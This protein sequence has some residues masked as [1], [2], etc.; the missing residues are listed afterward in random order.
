MASICGASL[1]LMAAGVPIKAPVAG[2]AMGLIQDEKRT[3]ILSD[4]LGDEDHLGD[5]DFKVAGTSKGITAMQMDI[6]ITGLTKE[7]LGKALEQAR[8]GRLHILEKMENTIAQ[9]RP[10]LSPL[11]PKLTVLKVPVDRI[12]DLIGPGGKNIRKII[13]ETGAT[14]DI[15]DDG[16][17]IIGA[18]DQASGDL[19]IKRVKD[20]TAEVEVGKYYRGKVVRIVDFGAFVEVYPKV[21]G[22]VHIS[23][24]EKRRVEKVSE[25]LKVGDMITVKCIEIDKES[26]KIRLSRKEALDYKGPLENE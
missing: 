18:T 22:L 19:A 4:I 20:Y 13:E 16:T 9:P 10:A 23:H 17:V 6:K 2:I 21:D 5:M 24:L 11:A 12:G 7:L 26:G 14:I 3:V 25:V 1:S 8:G 15:E